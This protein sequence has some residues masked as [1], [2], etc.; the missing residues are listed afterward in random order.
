V[1]LDKDIRKYLA[2]IG[3]KGGRKRIEHVTSE[4]QAA[5]ARARWKGTS[6][7]ERS[8]AAAKG[9]RTRRARRGKSPARL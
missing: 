9:W 4:Q 6:K 1:A 2:A 5:F 7:A 8:R 3:R